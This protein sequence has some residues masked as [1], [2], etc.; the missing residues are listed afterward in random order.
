MF[1]EY[2]SSNIKVVFSID[3]LKMSVFVIVWKA[4]WLL[5]IE[6]VCI[7][8]ICLYLV[9]NWSQ[10]F[11]W[12]SICVNSCSVSIISS[13]LINSSVSSYCPRKFWKYAIINFWFDLVLTNRR[14]LS[15]VWRRSSIV[16]L[17][18]QQ[19]GFLQT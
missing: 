17:V 1:T 18:D 11:S 3:S 4:D 16:Y 6:I 13:S 15:N 7:L 9:K 19:P 5:R 12:I 2:R 8:L 14:N 10:S